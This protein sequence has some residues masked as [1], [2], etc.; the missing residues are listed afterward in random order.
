MNWRLDKIVVIIM[1]FHL[2]LIAQQPQ[3]VTI[4]L[5]ISQDIPCGNPKMQPEVTMLGAG[6]KFNVVQGD[7][8]P[9]GTYQLKI[10]MSG[11]QTHCSKE[12][13]DADQKTHL[14]RR[15]LQARSREIE[16]R[17]TGDFPQEEPLDPK[18]ANLDGKDLRDKL[19]RPGNYR[20][21]IKM[22]GYRPIEENITI[23]VGAEAFVIQRMLITL[24]R[25][26]KEKISYDIAPPKNLGA[27]RIT[28]APQSSRSRQRIIK[29]GDRVKPGSYW[30]RITQKGYQPIVTKKHVWPGADPWVIEYQLVAKLVALDIRVNHDISPGSGL[31]AWRLT[32]IDPLGG[33]PRYV[34]SGNKIK[35]G[36]YY[37]S[38]DQPGYKYGA[39]R[40]IVILPGE[41]PYQIREKLIAKTR[42]I[43]SIR[44]VSA[45]QV[46]IKDP[47]T[48]K[49]RT[50]SFRDKLPVGKEVEL[51]IKFKKY[52]TVNYKDS[53]KP[54]EGPFHPRIHL[55]PLKRHEFSTRKTSLTIDGITY[56]YV[57]HCNNE[58][59][60]NHLITAEKGIRR[61]YYSIYVP[62]EAKS[63]RIYA[64]YLYSEHPLRSYLLTRFKHI[65]VAKL[66]DHLQRLQNE[67]SAALALKVIEELLKRYRS[68]RIFKK[69]SSREL[70]LLQ[71]YIAGWLKLSQFRE[72]SLK[73]RIKMVLYILAKIA[74]K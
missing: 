60:E 52:K 70:D 32:L 33:V 35:P 31:P 38:V 50:M 29:E 2:A 16:F 51:I 56:A 14:I 39:R 68:R 13:I 12:S 53:I 25:V 61:T 23:D 54:G 71:K 47:E 7:K 17:L 41:K 19:F 49:I 69:M 58:P 40:K 22:P 37:I 15:Q 3:L 26:V 45:Y 66:I 74:Q 30:M 67:K 36:T 55:I 34:I 27:Y 44:A 10:E 42:S 21:V 6:Q 9:P 64:G 8:L 72:A 11:Y 46:L 43:D 5:Q 57:I 4:K 63:I 24:P 1:L 73:I 28:I 20:L 48:D 18:I 65:D 62:K 59:V